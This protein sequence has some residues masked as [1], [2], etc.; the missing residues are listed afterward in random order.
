MPGYAAECRIDTT[1]QR[2][3]VVCTNQEWLGLAAHRRVI[4][5]TLARLAHGSP[6]APALPPV[7]ASWTPGSARA[8]EGVWVLESG[9]RIEIREQDGRL[10]LG[11][12][13]QDAVDLFQSALPAD[14]ARRHETARRAHGVLRAAVN[15]DTAALHIVLPPDDYRFLAPFLRD[16]LR[17]H[18][19]TFGELRTVTSLGAIDMPWPGGTRA[20]A[21]LQF[22]DHDSDIMLGWTSGKFTDVAFDEARPFPVLLGVAPLAEGGYAAFDLA[23]AR[24]VR[25]ALERA[26][27]GRERLH[28][29][30]EAGDAI[31]IPLQ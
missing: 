11:A 6:G 20:Y 21:R 28:V 22:P 7:V 31:A 5:N 15:A 12:R 23:T 16:Q 1:A 26:G 27:S 8:L 25:L 4:A 9:G 17:A 3:I 14:I 13:G 10:R 19:A 24:T 18:R 2:V 29:S 30:G